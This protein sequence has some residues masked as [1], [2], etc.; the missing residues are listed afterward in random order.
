MD[1]KTENKI[2]N[3]VFSNFKD[4]T[5]INIAHKGQSLKMCNKIY[6][7]NKKKFVKN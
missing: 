6:D 5:I 3:K 4:M 1:I 7:L 2:I